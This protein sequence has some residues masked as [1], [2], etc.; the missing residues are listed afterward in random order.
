MGEC[1]SRIWTMPESG[2]GGGG[3]EAG[4]ESETQPVILSLKVAFWPAPALSRIVAQDDS[5]EGLFSARVLKI[6]L[7]CGVHGCF[8]Q[9]QGE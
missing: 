5:N 8:W 7:H 2:R 1:C 3:G 4:K 6:S 9:L